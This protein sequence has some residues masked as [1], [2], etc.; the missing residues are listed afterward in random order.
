MRSRA[1][2]VA[3]PARHR[4][5]EH[6]KSK[7]SLM[8][9]CRTAKGMKW[10]VRSIMESA[11]SWLIYRVKVGAHRH[12]H[13]IEI[14]FPFGI[15]LAARAS[16]KSVSL[17]TRNMALQHVSIP[18]SH[19]TSLRRRAKQSNGKAQLTLEHNDDYRRPSPERS[20]NAHAPASPP[21]TLHG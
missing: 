3:F 21:K 18:Q 1:A 17:S 14:S 9:F 6:A 13:E 20:Q 2:S 12:A 19:N 11:L 5:H 7:R 4:E 15:S 8:P 10:T 16:I